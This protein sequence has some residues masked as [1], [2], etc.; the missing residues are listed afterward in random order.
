LDVGEKGVVID[1]RLVIAPEGG[2]RRCR[3][4]TA[5]T[6]IIGK[7]GKGGGWGTP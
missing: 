2:S 5:S 1:G 7:E 4:W 3:A 6:L